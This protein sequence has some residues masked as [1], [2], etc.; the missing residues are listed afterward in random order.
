MERPEPT[1]TFCGCF[2]GKGA[3]S[4]AR[5]LRK[6]EHE[7]NPYKIDGR[8]PPG[9]YMDSINL[10]LTDDAAEWAETNPDAA[11]LLSEDEPTTE[12]VLSFRNLFLE[13]FPAKSV[14]PAAA[15]FHTELGE[16]RQRPDETISTYYKRLLVLMTRGGARDRPAV[17]SL[18]VLESSTLGIILKSFA[19]GLYD[20][21]VRREATR[22]LTV[23]DRSLREL[24]ALAE[25]AFRSKRELQKLTEEE[26]RS[27]ELQFYRDMA[28]HAMPRERIDSMLAIYRAG[29]VSTD[30]MVNNNPFS[31]APPKIYRAD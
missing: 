28:A 27:I 11:R 29:P 26:N 19:L 23:P 9:R 15:S 2:S 22:G 30:W 25:N 4:A 13:R 21:D 20:E 24:C 8:I 17:G 7:L 3:M 10:L 16:F 12:S 18:S 31:P 5:W 14:E 6:L 1:F